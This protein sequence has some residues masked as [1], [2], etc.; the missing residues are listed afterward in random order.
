MALTPLD[1]HTKEF[2]RTIH[3]YAV[4]EVDE[5]LDEVVRDFE[6]SLR[7]RD[8][9]RDQVFSLQ[10]QLDQ[11]KQLEENLNRAFVTAQKTVD[12]M[13][14]QARLRA[15][16]V[17]KEAELQSERIQFGTQTKVRD[18]E[19]QY[20]SLTREISTFRAKSKALL[21]TYLNVLNEDQADDS[22]RIRSVGVHKT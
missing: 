14:E 20:E 13:T 8:Q 12:D 21:E 6:G 18:L 1:I 16:A 10:R 15:E 3:G 9:F 2:R 5:F 7:E 4:D 11:Y 17:I 22:A 19:Q